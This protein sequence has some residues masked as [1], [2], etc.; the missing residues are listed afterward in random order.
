MT[1]LAALLREAAENPEEDAPRLVLADWLDDHGQHD[2]AEV[3]RL[4]LELAR[5][6]EHDPRMPALR[7]RH[8]E[9]T[10]RNAAWFGD[11]PQWGSTWNSRGLLG[12]GA[13][14]SSLA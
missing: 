12:F 9:L 11:L 14:A 5:L 10:A 8:D 7:K 13:S 6:D 3:V 1:T 4:G 2:R